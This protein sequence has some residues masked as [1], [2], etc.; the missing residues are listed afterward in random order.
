MRRRSRSGAGDMI[1]RPSISIERPVLSLVLTVTLVALSRSR[2]SKAASTAFSS[3]ASGS[4]S[5]SRVERPAKDG[6]P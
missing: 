6:T 1:R 2:G 4:R 5:K 3:R